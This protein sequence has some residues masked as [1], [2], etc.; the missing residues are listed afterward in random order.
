LNTQLEELYFAQSDRAAVTAAGA[1]L[2]RQLVEEGRSFIIDLLA[3]GNTD[4]G[5]ESA[6]DVLAN[7][8]LY[9]AACRRHEI[10]GAEAET[11]ASSLREASAL[12]LHL[13][14]SMGVTPRF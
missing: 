3:E 7:V 6:F 4:E 13:G 1:V 5:F 11:G 10:A 14:A 2:K 8:G 9:M 12:A